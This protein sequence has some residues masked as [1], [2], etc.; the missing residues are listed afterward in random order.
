MEVWFKWFSFANGWFLASIYKGRGVCQTCLSKNKV[1]NHRFELLLYHRPYVGH[2]IWKFAYSW[3]QERCICSE[4][5]WSD[6]THPATVDHSGIFCICEVLRNLILI[7]FF[8]SKYSMSTWSK[9]WARHQYWSRQD[10]LVCLNQQSCGSC[11]GNVVDQLKNERLSIEQSCRCWWRPLI[12]KHSSSCRTLW[13]RRGTCSCN[14]SWSKR[15]TLNITLRNSITNIHCNAIKWCNHIFA[16]RGHK[17]WSSSW[18][19]WPLNL[20]QATSTG[21]L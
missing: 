20:C 4:P 11:Q 12:D 3:Y 15:S 17:H 2:L 21:H 16:H 10:K 14:V 7:T 5:S 18:S 9:A 19:S 8:I 13:S 6:R 1:V